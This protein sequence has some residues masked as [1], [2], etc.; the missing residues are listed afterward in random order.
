MPDLI[1]ASSRAFTGFLNYTRFYR[2][3]DL[4]NAARLNGEDVS[5]GSQVAMVASAYPKYFSEDQP[6]AREWLDEK[7]RGRQMEELRKMLR[8]A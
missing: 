6:T 1:R 2:F 5:K 8:A 3:N 7:F 4:L